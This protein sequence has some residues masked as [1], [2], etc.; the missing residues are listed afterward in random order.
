MADILKRPMF[1]KG[2]S[3]SDGVGITSGLT[4]RQNYEVGGG[5]VIPVIEEQ[6]QQMRPKRSENVGNF[7]MALGATAPDDPTKLQTF[8]Q[9]LS[10]AG[11]ATSAM[12]EAKEAEARKFKAGATQEVIKAMT[13][14]EKDQ[15]I[16]R[17]KMWAQTQRAAGK[18][19]TDE[20]AIAIWLN[21][22]ISQGSPY[23]KGQS[24]QDRILN[25][26]KDYSNPDGEFGF[27][28]AGA[29]KVSEIIVAYQDRNLPPGIQEKF[30]GPIDQ[31]GALIATED[32]GYEFRDMKQ[33]DEIY[34]TP[35]KIYVNPDDGQLYEYIGEGQFQKVNQ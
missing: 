21:A 18:D 30:K 8:G 9:V 4:S 11:T 16:R 13:D 23:L 3:A 14:P 1:R 2:G 5:A 15:L 20:Q 17:A 35:N 19:M 22:A 31:E 33:L 24:P 29:Q 10:K 7:L 34:Y 26:A 32:G 28:P 27:S 12:R 6:Y 25:M